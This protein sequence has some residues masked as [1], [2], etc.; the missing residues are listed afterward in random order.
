VEEDDMNIRSLKQRLVMTLIGLAIAG[1]W[2]VYAVITRFNFYNFITN[3]T[4]ISIAL[5][6]S[7]PLA[8]LLAETLWSDKK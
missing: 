8:F 5:I 4:I 3:P 6:V 7:V 1:L 2:G